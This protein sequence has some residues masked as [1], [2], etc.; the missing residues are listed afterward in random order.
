MEKPEEQSMSPNTQRPP[1]RSV[2]DQDV[3]KERRRI[4]SGNGATKAEAK[5]S[6]GPGAEAQRIELPFSYVIKHQRLV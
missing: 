1:H 2:L 4:W 5:K 6:T 3:A